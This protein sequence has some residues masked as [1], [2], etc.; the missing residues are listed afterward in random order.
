MMAAAGWR[1]SYGGGGARFTACTNS[2]LVIRGADTCAD[3]AT[4]AAGI[5]QGCAGRRAECAVHSTCSAVCAA[6][7]VYSSRSAVVRCAE[8]LVR[9]MGAREKDCSESAVNRLERARPTEG[10]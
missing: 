5:R 7:R 10:R 3:R 9:C 6:H 4:R 8:R 1:T 2:W